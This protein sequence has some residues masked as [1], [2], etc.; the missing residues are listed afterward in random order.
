MLPSIFRNSFL[1]SEPIVRIMNFSSHAASMG[2]EK[3]VQNFGG[4]C[5]GN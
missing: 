1:L 2:K 5:L 3:F 4:E